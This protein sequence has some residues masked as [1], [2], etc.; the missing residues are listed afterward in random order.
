MNLP[1]NE[2][3]AVGLV[4]RT[5]RERAG[6]SQGAVAKHLGISQS[7]VSLLESGRQQWTVEYLN[8]FGDLCGMRGWELLR[9]AAPGDAERDPEEAKM[10]SLYLRRLGDAGVPHELE[11]YRARREGRARDASRAFMR[12]SRAILAVESPSSIPGVDRVVRYAKRLLLGAT[13]PGADDP[14]G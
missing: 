4:A 8:A 7:S 10:L 2:N 6:L 3:E 14:E 5:I 12:M 1:H 11:S 9:R 13:P